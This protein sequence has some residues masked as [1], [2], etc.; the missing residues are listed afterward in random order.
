[1][2]LDNC[3]ILI[4]GDGGTNTVTLSKGQMIVNGIVTVQALTSGKLQ[5]GVGDT[6]AN[7]FNVL[8]LPGSKLIIDNGAYI[9][10][11]NIGH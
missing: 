2:Y 6:I 10:D 8:I 9:I 5:F 3:N 7:N 1:L 11:K 4:S